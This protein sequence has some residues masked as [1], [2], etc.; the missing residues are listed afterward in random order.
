[1]EFLRAEIRAMTASFRYPMFIVGYQP[2]YRVP[3]VSTIY[4][5]LSA[6]KG[7]KVG[8]ADLMVGYDFVSR[9]SG[10]D[11][12]RLRIYG[13]EKTRKPASFL[14]T[15]VIWREFLYDCTLTLYLSDLSFEKYLRNP[16]YNILLGRQSDLAC[17]SDIKRVDLEKEAEVEINNTIVPFTGEMSGQVVSLPSDFTDKAERKP[18]NVRSYCIVE[19]PQV[20]SNGYLDPERD[21]GVYLHGTNN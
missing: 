20:T 8:P 15:D 5:L 14:G 21:I 12:E 17:V 4:G 7:E 2:T 19:S 13:D 11:L 18:L 3:P 9:G 16:Y 10:R 6:A 1:M